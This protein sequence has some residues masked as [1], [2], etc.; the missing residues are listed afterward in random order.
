MV[1]SRFKNTTQV[2]AMENLT[3]NFKLHRQRIKTFASE[4]TAN[5]HSEKAF[6]CHSGKQL[7]SA[8]SAEKI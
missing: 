2:A 5:Q 8:I 6:K 7:A 3:R 4:L 1:V